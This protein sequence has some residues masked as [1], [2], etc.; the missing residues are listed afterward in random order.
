MDTTDFV[1][2]KGY[3]IA[4]QESVIEGARNGLNIMAAMTSKGQKA[5]IEKD[6]TTRGT[7]SKRS[8]VFDKATGTDL[9]KM[10]SEAGVL[11]RAEYLAL[12]EG[13]YVKKS[14]SGGTVA[15]P[16]TAARDGSFSQKVSKEY[17]TSRLRNKIVRGKYKHN[18]RSRKAR[19]VAQAAVAYREGKLFR[20]NDRIYQ[21]TRFSSV[22]GKTSIKTRMLYSITKKRVK[23]NKKPTLQPAMMKPVND[24]PMIIKSQ[25]RKAIR[26]N[27]LVHNIELTL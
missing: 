14:K 7:F 18:F 4:V 5:N 17:Y 19:A 16:T 8:V 2:K 11:R 22:N 15:V 1:K 25:I 21:V 12:H 20:R 10:Q 27:K 13:G 23:I 3:L 26:K 24:G 9:N 6:F